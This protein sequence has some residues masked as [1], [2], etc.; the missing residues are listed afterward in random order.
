M[1]NL[2]Q[3]TND[4]YECTDRTPGGYSICIPKD[5]LQAQKIMQKSHIPTIYEGVSLT[6]GD[7]RKNYWIPILQGLAKKVRIKFFGCKRFQV[8]AF[9]NP[10][11]GALLLD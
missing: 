5:S 1:L 7:V 2:Q 10:T 9:P 8:T 11:P 4:I 3:N 6:M